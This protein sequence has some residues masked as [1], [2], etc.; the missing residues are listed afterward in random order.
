MSFVFESRDEADD[1]L[2][3]DEYANTKPSFPLL[4][5]A[6]PERR[7]KSFPSHQ[8]LPKGQLHSRAE[9]LASIMSSQTIYQLPLGIFQIFEQ[10]PQD[11][12]TQPISGCPLSQRTFT[13]NTFPPPSSHPSHPTAFS[14]SQWRLS[15]LSQPTKKYLLLSILWSKSVSR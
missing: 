3:L 14:P 15:Q 13:M 2:G 8:G 10:Q 7:V 5:R 12:S 4:H 1:D 6:G 11:T 9:E